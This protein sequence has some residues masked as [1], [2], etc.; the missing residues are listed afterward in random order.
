MYMVLNI[1]KQLIIG[2]MIKSDKY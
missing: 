1:I 2:L